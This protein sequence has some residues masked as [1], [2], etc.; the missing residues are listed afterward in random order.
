[1]LV[2]SLLELIEEPV[3]SVLC[4]PPDV[5]DHFHLFEELA[6][7]EPKR[8]TKDEVILILSTAIVQDDGQLLAGGAIFSYPPKL[9]K[10]FYKERGDVVASLPPLIFRVT[11]C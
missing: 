3:A 10:P 11:I 8:Q 1:M 9:T 4:V 2:I 6:F 7:N 5:K